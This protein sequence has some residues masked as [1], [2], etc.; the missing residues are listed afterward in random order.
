M[1]YWLVFLLFLLGGFVVTEFYFRW[2]HK[3]TVIVKVIDQ[4]GSERFV[5]IKPG[6]DP[7]VEKLIASLKKKQGVV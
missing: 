7:E 3:K 6:K 1:S 2:T 4:D 5:E